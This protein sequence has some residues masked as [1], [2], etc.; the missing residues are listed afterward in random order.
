M[1]S[2]EQRIFQERVEKYVSDLG[3]LN[4]VCQQR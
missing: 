4:A 1:N 3:Q 2:D